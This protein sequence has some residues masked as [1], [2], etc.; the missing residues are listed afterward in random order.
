[1]I[2]HTAL[3]LSAIVLGI[4]AALAPGPYLTL[5]V[6]ETLLHGKAR[7]VKTVL[8]PVLG[9]LFIV[10]LSYFV[11]SHFKNLDTGL[12]VVA[13]IGALYVGYLSYSL[14]G[15]RLSDLVIKTIRPL[16]F[17]KLASVNLMNP[18]V[19]MFWFTVGAPLSMSSGHG[20]LWDI[21]F[22]VVFYLSLVGSKLLVVYTVDWFSIFLTGMRYVFTMRLLGGALLLFAIYFLRDGLQFFGVL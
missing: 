4:P 6:S 18:N 14:L 11:V 17:Y 20:T 22:V 2:S 13:I 1:M 16:S 3:L 15:L 21:L 8:I 12:G 9:D 10:I 5:I 19:Y 7:G